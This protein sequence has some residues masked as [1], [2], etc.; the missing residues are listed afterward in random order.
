MILKNSRRG[1]SCRSD[2]SSSSLRFENLTVEIKL[3]VLQEINNV[4]LYN[5]NFKY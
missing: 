3:F 2:T 1:H 5:N 4:N